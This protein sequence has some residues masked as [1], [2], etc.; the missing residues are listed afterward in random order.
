MNLRIVVLSSAIFLSACATT[1]ETKSIGAEQ[2]TR[3]QFQAGQ[4]GILIMNTAGDLNCDRIT[5]GVN[6]KGSNTNTVIST[7]RDP[8]YKSSAPITL[9]LE[10]GAYTVNRGSCFRE[11]YY[12]S[13]LPNLF[14]WFANVELAGGEVV[15]MGTLNIKKFEYQ[16]DSGRKG[17]SAFLLEGVAQASY[18]TYEM[19]DMSAEV[20][21]RIAAKEPD[22]ASRMVLRRPRQVISN[23]DFS[24]AL[25]TAYAAGPDGKA[26]T[27][28]LARQRL[29]EALVRLFTQ[30]EG[31]QS[32]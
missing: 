7:R 32:P 25:E 24:N 17:L 6:R 3:E 13:E 4:A 8:G 26:P 12:P 18:V 11:G 10:P 28:E 19:A 16:T 14:R 21:E 27:R 9:V 29:G 1:S 20:R 2:A 5:L 15:Y 22:L 31:P 23:D 30:R